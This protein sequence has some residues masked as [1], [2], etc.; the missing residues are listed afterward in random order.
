MSNWLPLIWIITAIVVA[1]GASIYMSVHLKN[2]SVELP[3]DFTDAK[4]VTPSNNYI[5]Y[6]LDNSFSMTA[7]KNVEKESVRAVLPIEN[8]CKSAYLDPIMRKVQDNL[9]YKLWHQL[10]WT[11]PNTTWVQTQQQS[12][13]SVQWLCLGPDYYH[14]I[15]RAELHRSEWKWSFTKV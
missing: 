7:F 1:L 11:I 13:T 12:L 2:R 5:D 14:F 6:V 8:V 10:I 9:N 15:A 4:N 3:H